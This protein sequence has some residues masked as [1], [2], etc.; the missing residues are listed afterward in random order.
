[1]IQS[2][3]SMC[4]CVCGA[5]QNVPLDKQYAPTRTW[6]YKQGHKHTEVCNEHKNA[7]SPKKA[8][9]SGKWY[10]H[11][12]AERIWRK[13]ST[14][15]LERMRTS[16]EWV[17]WTKKRL[18]PA[19]YTSDI[20]GIFATAD[21][22]TLCKHYNDANRNHICSMYPAYHSTSFRRCKHNRWRNNNRTDGAKRAGENG[23]EQKEKRKRKGER[24]AVEAL[25]AEMRGD[26]ETCQ[27]V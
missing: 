21:W 6:T 22:K 8:T 14:M 23:V 15:G 25:W 3:W 1:M 24:V 13:R 4:V 20:M 10:S 12:H 9:I 16:A 18:E 2:S 17:R 11:K 19:K 7:S 5:N 27:P 26:I